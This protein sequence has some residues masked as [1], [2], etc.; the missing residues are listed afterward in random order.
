MRYCFQPLIAFISCSQLKPLTELLLCLTLS[1]NVHSERKSAA[2]SPSRMGLGATSWN[3]LLLSHGDAVTLPASSLGLW[4][5]PT[6]MAWEDTQ[7]MQTWRCKVVC[8]KV[9]RLW[10]FWAALALPVLK[11]RFRKSQSLYGCL[12]RGP[13]GSHRQTSESKSPGGGSLWQPRGKRPH[14]HSLW[15]PPSPAGWVSARRTGRGPG[16]HKR[17]KSS[18]QG[19]WDV[20]CLEVAKPPPTTYFQK[21]WLTTLWPGMKNLRDT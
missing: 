9:P 17:P 19:C 3:P 18:P 14:S 7:S 21:L 12:R 1:D 13:M 11:R 8:H 15:L 16:V 4:D 20:L 2:D 10:L 5:A 6:V